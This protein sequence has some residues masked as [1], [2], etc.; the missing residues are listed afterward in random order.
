[1]KHF[2]IFMV[3]IFSGLSFFYYHK[4]DKAQMI[5]DRTI[6]IY[7]SSSF[8]AKWGPGPA[9]KELFEKQ[10]IF[11]IEFLESPDIAMTLQKISF[12]N[13]NSTADLV[14]GLDQFDL[15]RQ[16]TKIEWQPITQTI[17]ADYVPDIERAL[18]NQ[19]RFMAY[20][21]AP[22]TFVGRQDMSVQV[23]Q[24]EDL[25]KPELKGRIALQDPRT[26][27]PGLQ[28]LIWIFETKPTEQAIVFLKALMKQAHSFSSSWSGAYGL[29]KNRQADLVFSYVTSPI[30]HVVEEKDSTFVSLEMKEAL[31]LQ[32]EFAGIPATCKNCQGAE[33]FL[34]FM[35]TREAQK[36]IMAKNYMLPV[37]ERVKDATE[38]D[39]IKVY[40]TVPVKFYDQDRIDKWINQWTEIRKNE[41]L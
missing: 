6:R 24:L 21:W 1:M 32:V 16:A 35:L 39:A 22:M 41:G 12:E 10:N 31:P 11:K 29:F 19:T 13:K 40:R 27:S 38:F 4:E 9:L 5:E 18:K 33:Q 7:A 34:R 25:L 20:D 17:T 36:I 30:Y 26:S 8:I 14:L 28:M 15:S 37:V 3:L 23:N 2:I